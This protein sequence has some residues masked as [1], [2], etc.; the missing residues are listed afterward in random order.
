MAGALMGKI[1]IY[2]FTW[3]FLNSIRI[4]LGMAGMSPRGMLDP[5]AAKGKKLRER[6]RASETESKR[7]Q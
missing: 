4:V 1:M 6:E 2:N 5:A 3:Q 7:E